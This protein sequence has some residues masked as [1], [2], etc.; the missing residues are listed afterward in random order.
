M[1]SLHDIWVESGPVCGAPESEYSKPLDYL[2]YYEGELAPLRQEQLT[3]LEIGV[4]RG[5]FLETLGRYCPNGRI[6]GIDFQPE[7]ATFSA[8]NV[9]LF[10]GDQGDQAGLDALLRENTPDGIDIIID[11]ASHIGELTRSAFEVAIEWLKPG[12]RYYIEDWGTGY[13]DDWPDGAQ[14][15]HPTFSGKNA[16]GFASRFISHDA[17]MTGVVKELID[18]VGAPEKIAA[19]PIAA[20]TVTPGIV[21]LVKGA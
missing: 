20:M 11:D 21:K 4:F 2:N 1:K 16:A 6:L 7:R 9:Q 5:Q 3:V 8:P 17:G 10:R 19:T 18:H 13:W 14:I 15:Q 12:G